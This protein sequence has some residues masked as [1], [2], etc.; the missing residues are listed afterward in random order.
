MVAI[1]V[2]LLILMKCVICLNTLKGLFLF[3]EQSCAGKSAPKSTLTKDALSYWKWPKTTDVWTMP[4]GLTSCKVSHGDL[5]QECLSYFWT[6]VIKHLMW[7]LQ[8]GWQRMRLLSGI[9]DSKDMS[10]SKLQELI[11]DREAWRA[12]VHGVAKSQTRLS[13]WTDWL[14]VL[15]HQGLNNLQALTYFIFT[16]RIS[17]W[18]RLKEIA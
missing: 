4:G 10:L 17:D 3:T 6:N 8:R 18:L 13:N 9:T 11:M 1:L 15:N 16:V 2:T 14:R 5:Y 7:V 12:A